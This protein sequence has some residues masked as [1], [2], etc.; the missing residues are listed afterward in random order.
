MP[1]QAFRD[2]IHPDDLPA[3]EHAL[4]EATSKHSSFC[5]EYRVIHNDGVT[6]HVVAVGQFDCGPTGDL[7]LEGILCD[8][9]AQKAAEQALAASLASI[10]EL[11]GSIVHEI[12]QPL[13]GIIMSAEAC[14]R[15]LRR[16]P[17]SRKRP[18]NP[19]CRS[20]NRRRERRM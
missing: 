6:L 7:E 10:G 18:A 2:R 11:A 14:L 20:S 3:L 15:W 4:A 8:V 9:T 19:L 13:T 17:A 16:I 12:N 5:G 1:F